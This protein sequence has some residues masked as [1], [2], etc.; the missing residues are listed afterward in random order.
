M[1]EQPIDIKEIARLNEVIGNLNAALAMKSG[2][3]ERVRSDA[4]LFQKQRDEAERKIGVLQRDTDKFREQ[5]RNEAKPRLQWYRELFCPDHDPSQDESWRQYG[6]PVCMAGREN[7]EAVDAKNALMCRDDDGVTRITWGQLAEKKAQRVAKIQGE[8]D[9]IK[10]ILCEFHGG[11]PNDD[12]I[13]GLEQLIKQARSAMPLTEPKPDFKPVVEF[14]NANCEP[15]TAPTTYLCRCKQCEQPFY[16]VDRN[17]TL[18]DG[19]VPL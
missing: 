9:K 14:Y 2:E 4:E 16:S 13:E 15:K 8:L 7:K 12:A 1:S 19:C 11:L 17:A 3:C 6:C 10:D 5:Q 18:C